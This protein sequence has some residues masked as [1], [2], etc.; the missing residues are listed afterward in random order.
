MNKKLF[1]IYHGS[2]NAT[3]IFNV[4]SLKNIFISL[5]FYK[6]L[7]IKRK[8]LKFLFTI[9]L[10]VLYVLS[11]FIK[12]N[13]LSTLKE[14]NS[15]LKKI[16]NGI[17]FNIDE[18]SSVF[19]SSTRDKVIINHENQYFEKFSFN[20]SIPKT[21]HEIEMYNVLSQRKYRHFLISKIKDIQQE[22]DICK[23]KLYNNF[24]EQKIKVVNNNI[25]VEALVELFKVNKM[26]FIELSNIYLRLKADPYI[27]ENMQESI[28]KVEKLYSYEKKILVGFVHWDFKVW[29]IQ[30]YENKILIYDFEE[31]KLDGLPMEDL[32]NY[33]IDA[34]VMSGESIENIIVFIEGFNFKNLMESYKNKLNIHTDQNLLLILYLFNRVI[35]YNKNGSVEVVDKY[36]KL[37]QQILDSL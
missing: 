12:M 7:G 1:Y 32:C 13:K 37:I 15:F 4:S 3:Y 34:K 27:K 23:F 6:P 19:V 31:S 29:N 17:N 26:S 16:K 11:K 30:S 24:K 33:Y 28:L 21:I 25:L 9:Y 5:E 18:K 20:R 10:V 14:I 35:F 36:V 2:N 8:F 22:K